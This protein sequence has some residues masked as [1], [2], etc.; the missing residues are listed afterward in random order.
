LDITHNG[1][2][3]A[4]DGQAGAHAVSGNDADTKQDASAEL[5]ATASTDSSIHS[6]GQNVVNENT[7]AP[8]AVTLAKVYLIILMLRNTSTFK[9]TLI[10][11]T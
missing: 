8:A 10:V 7:A 5:L 3:A 11:T 9:Q 4:I 1:Q 2:G 6:D